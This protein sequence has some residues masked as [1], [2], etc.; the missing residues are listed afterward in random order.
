MEA[1]P[2][3]TDLFGSKIRTYYYYYS[4]EAGHYAGQRRTWPLP[5]GAYHMECTG[6]PME[7]VH[8]KGV[9]ALQYNGRAIAFSLIMVSTCGH[10]GSWSTM[11]P[12][13]GRKQE[14]DRLGFLRP[15][16]IAGSVDALG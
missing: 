16:L 15:L 8:L 5:L 11:G 2:L 13:K 12:K 7:R 4:L 10:R 3:N 1:Y 14:N 9:G 6:R